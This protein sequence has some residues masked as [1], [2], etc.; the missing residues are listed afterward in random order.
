MIRNHSFGLY[1]IDSFLRR[2]QGYRVE[3][4]EPVL[5]CTSKCTHAWSVPMQTTINSSCDILLVSPESL[6]P[7]TPAPRQ[8]ALITNM[9]LQMRGA[10]HWPWRYFQ[11]VEAFY[12]FDL[13]REEASLVDV[14]WP[15]MQKIRDTQRMFMQLH[16]TNRSKRFT[17]VLS[18]S[19]FYHSTVFLTAGANTANVSCTLVS[20]APRKSKL[21]AIFIRHFA[22][23]YFTWPVS[24]QAVFS[25][26][27]SS[28]VIF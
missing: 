26:L 10:I 13:I 21:Q 11:L 14:I 28:E 24:F 22:R 3:T 7:T 9:E 6:H 1:S 16:F 2:R 20:Q 23:H 18:E 15:T 27:K 25:S 12:R 4:P 17:R 19:N 5:Q 8:K